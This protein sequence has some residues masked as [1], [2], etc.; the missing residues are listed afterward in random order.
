MQ[1]ATMITLAC[2]A[3]PVAVSA[4]G[5]LALNRW[6]AR[7]TASLRDRCLRAMSPVTEQAGLSLSRFSGA[8]DLL[9]FEF[10]P[11]GGSVD[12]PSLTVWINLHHRDI[13]DLSVHVWLGSRGARSEGK[14]IPFS[15]EA[16]LDS[17]LS[18]L[19]S[20][21]AFLLPAQDPVQPA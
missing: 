18:Q 14:A 2:C 20:L 1:T 12:H 5:A 8:G 10:V 15:G 3:T 17:A 21:L 16:E 7:R 13:P 11:T 19:V 6:S 9:Q 4:L